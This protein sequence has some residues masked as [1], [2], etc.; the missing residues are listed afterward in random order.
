MRC[1]LRTVK[2]SLQTVYPFYRSV[3]SVWIDKPYITALAMKK[4]PV[5]ICDLRTVKHSLQTVYPCWRSVRSV[6]IDTWFIRTVTVR[7]YW[8]TLSKVMVLVVFLSKTRK[9]IKLCATFAVCKFL[10]VFY[11][12]NEANLRDRSNWSLFIQNPGHF[13]GNLNKSKLKSSKCQGVAC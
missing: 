2:H 4:S 11:H 10:A 7:V 6:R 13:N 5:M 1:D 8:T 9:K 12:A 3:R